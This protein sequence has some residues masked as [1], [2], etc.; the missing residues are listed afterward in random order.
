MYTAHWIRKIPLFLRRPFLILILKELLPNLQYGYLFVLFISNVAKYNIMY[1][2]CRICSRFSGCIGKG[3]EKA[4]YYVTNLVHE[5]VCKLRDIQV[6]LIFKGT[7][8]A[9]GQLISKWFLGSS[10]SSKK[11]TNEFNF[12]TYYE[13]CF[14]S[15]FGGNRRPQKT[16]SK[17]IDL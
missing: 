8:W 14:R 7:T 13:T 9:K 11:R 4:T 15:F 5:N 3:V 6:I 12:T 10:I 2:G 1:W 16:I 17:L